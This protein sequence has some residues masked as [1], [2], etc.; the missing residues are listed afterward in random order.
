MSHETS[1][2]STPFYLWHLPAHVSVDILQWWFSQFRAHQ[3][4]PEDLF[5][6]RL[7]DLVPGDSDQTQWEPALVM[8]S[9]LFREHTA[10][11]PRG[12][13]RTDTSSTV[14]KHHTFLKATPTSFNQ[15]PHLPILDARCNESNNT[16]NYICS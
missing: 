15:T 16:R 12:S 2:L 11:H 7:L 13:S 5:K 10:P 1:L 3:K 8:L 4:H 6:H 9:L 14:R